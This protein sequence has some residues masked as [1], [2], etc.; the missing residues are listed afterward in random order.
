MG[1]KGLSWRHADGSAKNY[2]SKGNSVGNGVT[3]R[4][5]LVTLVTEAFVQI[6]DLLSKR[7]LG[8][9]KRALDRG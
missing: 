8:I 4:T 3:C 1:F 7:S 9:F 5:G 6:D 2:T